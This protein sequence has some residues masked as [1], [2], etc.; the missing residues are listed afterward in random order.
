MNNP[1]PI[2]LMFYQFLMN[3]NCSH[4]YKTIGRVTKPWFACGK[5][6]IRKERNCL[7]ICKWKQF[8]CQTKF[9]KNCSQNLNVAWQTWNLHNVLSSTGVAAKVKQ[10]TTEGKS[11]SRPCQEIQPNCDQLSQQWKQT[12]PKVQ[13]DRWKRREKGEACGRNVE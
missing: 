7:P 11:G 4:S 3:L 8:V 10:K 6:V 1:L 12:N 2:S 13:I 5:H 9:K